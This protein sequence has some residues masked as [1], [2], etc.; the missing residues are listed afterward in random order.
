MERLKFAR[1]SCYVL[2]CGSQSVAKTFYSFI[3][4]A[5]IVVL[6]GTVVSADVVVKLY[7][8]RRKPLFYAERANSALQKVKKRIFF[9]HTL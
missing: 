5:N 7:Q 1:E 4:P 6:C 8:V 2:F 9:I 3:L